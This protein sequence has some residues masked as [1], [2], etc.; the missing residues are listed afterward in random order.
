MYVPPFFEM[1]KQFAL[2]HYQDLTM[3]TQPT[4]I[5]SYPY[6]FASPFIICLQICH[7][8]ILKFVI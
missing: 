4:K 2:L 3:L 8:L 5:H 1:N 7:T 6:T